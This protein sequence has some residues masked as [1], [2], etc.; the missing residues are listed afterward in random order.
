LIPQ[1]VVLNKSDLIKRADIEALERQ[2]V[3]DNPVDCVSISAIRPD[4]LRPLV[5][6]VAIRMGKF[7]LSEP[8][9]VA[10]G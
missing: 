4:T 10:T 3:L 8:G 1:I 7:A 2:I 9:A 5:E 6:G